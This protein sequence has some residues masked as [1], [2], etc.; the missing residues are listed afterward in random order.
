MTTNDMEPVEQLPQVDA[1]VEREIERVMPAFAELAIAKP[2]MPFHEWEVVAKE[3][4]RALLIPELTAYG[5]QQ[6]AA[7]RKAMPC[8]RVN[9]QRETREL[10]CRALLRARTM[11][12]QPFEPVKL[13][14]SCEVTG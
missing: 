11:T 3:L 12:G 7:G 8:Y 5:A 10:D 4:L 1:A 6:Y 14:P 13:C 9:W 2:R